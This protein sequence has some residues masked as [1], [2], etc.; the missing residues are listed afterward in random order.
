MLVPDKP[1][2]GSWNVVDCK[3]M[4]PKPISAWAVID[5][6]LD[7]RDAE[8][9]AHR[10]V[11]KLTECLRALGMEV[12]PIVIARLSFPFIR[13]G[14]VPCRS[15]DDM[16]LMV[17]TDILPVSCYKA[18]VGSMSVANVCCRL[19]FSHGLRDHEYS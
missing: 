4:D 2:N 6:S 18:G 19:Q 13:N 10:F 8:S 11:D 5:Y 3:F 15:D 14:S 1:K 7:K 16:R 12:S 17:I 9:R